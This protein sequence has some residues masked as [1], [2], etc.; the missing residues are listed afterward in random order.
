MRLLLFIF[1]ILF[2]LVSQHSDAQNAGLD[3]RRAELKRLLNDEWE[4]TLRSSPEFATMVGDDRYNDRLSDF[5]AK[6]IAADL[7]HERQALARFEALDEVI[8]EMKKEE[9]DASANQ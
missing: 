4:Y 8:L 5:S 7:E 2:A 3:S 1:L 6:G 9:N